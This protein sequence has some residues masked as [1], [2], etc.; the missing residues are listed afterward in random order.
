MKTTHEFCLFVEGADLTVAG[1]VERLECVGYS[2]PAAAARDGIQALVFVRAA[3]RLAD[4]VEAV[5][6]DAEQIEG[7]SI[8]RDF[9]TGTAAAFDPR[10]LDSIGLCAEAARAGAAGTASTA[11]VRPARRARRPRHR[12]SATSLT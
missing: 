6:S 12:S 7:V 11:P 2:H 5:A 8:A 10:T 1:T 3:D 9:R 4:A